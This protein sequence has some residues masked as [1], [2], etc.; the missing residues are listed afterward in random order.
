MTLQLVLICG[1]Y[2][3]KKTEIEEESTA[4]QIVDIEKDRIFLLTDKAIYRIA[5]NFLTK[6]PL[7]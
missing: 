3:I 2:Y 7:K 5:Y 4:L 6:K 1:V